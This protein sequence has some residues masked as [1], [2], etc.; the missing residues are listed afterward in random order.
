[1]ASLIGLILD[2]GITFSG[3]ITGILDRVKVRVEPGKILI[4]YP[5]DIATSKGQA[6]TKRTQIL[7]RA[8]NQKISFCAI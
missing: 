5:K 8:F 2:F 6:V 7:E 1:M 3:G 4:L